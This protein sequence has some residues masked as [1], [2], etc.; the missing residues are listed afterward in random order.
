MRKVILSLFFLAI[1]PGFL[2]GQGTFN[3]KG[4]ITDAKLGEPLIGASVILKPFNLGAMAD[5]NGDYSF[6]VPID[7]AKGKMAE[8]TVSYVNYKKKSVKLVLSGFN[9]TQNFALE[10]DVFQSEEIVI[11]GIASKT[12]KAVAEI[13]VG[14]VSATDLQKVNTYGSL[15]Q[16]V[17]GKVAGVQLNTSSGNVGS[18]WRFNI[19]G[20]GGSLSGSGQPTIYIDGIRVDNQEVIGFGVGGQGVSTL[21]NFN[22]NDIEKIEFLKGSAAAAMY[23]TSGANGVVV[24]TTKSGAVGAGGGVLPISV[25]YKFNYGFNERLVKYS[26]DDFVTANDAN[27]NWQK[28]PIRDNNL[29]V[30]GGYASLKYY[31]S[32]SSRTEYGILPANYLDRKGTNVK[33]SAVPTSNLSVVFSAGY[34]VSKGQ[35]PTNDNIIY[36]WLG[37]TLLQPTSYQYIPEISLR[38]I[39]DANDNRTFRGSAIASYK[40]LPQL[41]LYGS[42]GYE[43]SQYRQQRL[44]PYGYNYGGLVGTKGE[45]AI[46]NRSTNNYNYEFN[47]KY[48]WEPI[49]QLSITSIVGG[50]FFDRYFADQNIIGQQFGSG[51]IISEGSLLDITGY[52]ESSFNTREGGL[53]TEHSANY[54]DQYFVTI[55]LKREFSSVIGKSAPS[56]F[57]P[58]GSFAIRLDKYDF[59][60][61]FVDL[62][63]FRMAYGI[64][65]TPPGLTDGIPIA[66]T[67][68]KG[69]YGAGALI[70]SLGNSAIK[71]ESSKELEVGLDLEL[72]KELSLEM[73]YY[74]RNNNNAII[75]FPLSSSTGKTRANLPY[76]VGAMKAWGLETMIQYFP[77]K[78][79]DY[80]LDFSLIWNYQ[81]NEVTDLGGAQDIYAGFN[82]SNVI[83]AGLPRSEFYA[84]KVLGATFDAAGKYF[85][86]KATTENQR[87]GNPIPN[88]SGSITINFKFLKNFVLYGFGEFGLKNK[89]Y[90]YTL[91][92][93][94]RTGNNPY[95]NNLSAQLA[96]LTPNTQEYIDV[97]NKYAKTDGRFV[98]NYLEDAS[99]LAIR[100]LSLSYDFTDL[101]G[102]FDL[103]GYVK[104]VTFGLSARNV[105]R[106]TKYSGPDFEINSLGAR[107]IAQGID[108]LTLQTPRTVNFW[109]R[110]G[111]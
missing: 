19:R 64:T 52:G 97:A 101:L 13:A 24:I 111:F 46:Y 60:P 83:K 33:I 63:K 41:E 95:R 2:L 29:S 106:I 5:I 37:N 6:D 9:I 86:V 78:G 105:L 40:L 43:N 58:K 80:S 92:F 74:N 59:L 61:S 109:V 16:L 85:G 103:L 15:S 25:D 57:Y 45:K 54:L 35:R 51:L 84:P 100:E 21:S 28:G 62:A 98:D 36:G 1:L 89:V 11:T 50:Q 68:Q 72:F 49:D 96:T 32:F 66:W 67:F 77:I 23:G 90:N 91:A 99:Y 110:L 12:S 88:H 26:T 20:G 56:I 55:G 39:N 107:S 17:Q 71:P 38:A 34:I 4:K 31:A 94:A 7:L 102:E 104:Y 82:S 87:L 81:K 93:G 48:F 44:Y 14:R 10:E 73:T 108:F 8:L 79:V 65:G 3:I 30:A 22:S 75:F 47:T 18:G 76:N 42:F 27:A 69:G 70:N 53:Y